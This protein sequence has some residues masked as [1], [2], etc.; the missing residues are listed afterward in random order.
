MRP[1]TNASRCSF[2]HVYDA[3]YAGQA[4]FLTAQ[5]A[6]LR[7]VFG[8][9]PRALLDVGCGTGIQLAALSQSGYS[10][11]GIDI[12]PLM[13]AAARRK[14]PAAMLIRADLRWLPFGQSYTGAL[15][16]ES[17]LAYLL[18][19]ADLRLALNSIG[20][21]LEPGGRLVVD[22]FDYPGSLGTRNMEPQE[23]FFA[24]PEMQVVVRESHH[25]EKRNRTWEMQ[26]EF[27]LDEAGER[28]RF[29]VTHVLRIRTMDDYAQGLESAGFE[30]EQ[31][32]TGYPQAPESLGR[33][34]RIILVARR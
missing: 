7:E 14:M 28:Y 4:A 5:I 2:A 22:V 32:L 18:S 17:P 20:N 21:A 27:D 1:P 33:E 6:F 13:L 16:L 26:Q 15:C 9:S 24:T 25:Y 34:R 19:N 10:V 23:A 30:V 11:T 3:L 31:A 29:A 8:P 12:E